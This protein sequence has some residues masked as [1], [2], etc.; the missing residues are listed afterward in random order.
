MLEQ[1][2]WIAGIVGTAVAMLGLL[3][4][5]ASKKNTSSKQNA[6]VSGRNNTVSQSVDNGAGGGTNKK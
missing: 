1:V 3:L 6:K 2:Y 4:R 5:A